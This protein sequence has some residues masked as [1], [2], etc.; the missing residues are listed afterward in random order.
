MLD[1]KKIAGR[2]MHSE[3]PEE[4]SQLPGVWRRIS[5]SLGRGVE[6][7]ESRMIRAPG[8]EKLS[9]VLKKKMPVNGKGSPF[10]KNGKKRLSGPTQYHQEENVQLRHS[11]CSERGR[12]ENAA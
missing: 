1:L 9:K 7:R 10:K 3:R 2:G 8:R 12:H 11:K 6:Y 5:G 4:K